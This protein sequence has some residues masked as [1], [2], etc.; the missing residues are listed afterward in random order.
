[1][2]TRR[3][4]FERKIILV[5]GGASRA[6]IGR[7]SF[8]PD[9]PS[10]KYSTCATDGHNW[11]PSCHLH[12]T[13]DGVEARGDVGV[14]GCHGNSGLGF[15]QRDRSG[16]PGQPNKKL[17]GPQEDGSPAE[18]PA[19]RT[20]HKHGGS[21]ILEFA[22]LSRKE[23]ETKLRETAA[24]NSRCS[25]I[26]GDNCG[27]GYLPGA[28]DDN[29]WLTGGGTPG[30]RCSNIG[31]DNCGTGYLPGAGDDND[32]LTGGGGT[33]GKRCSN[34]GGDNCGTGYLPGAGDDN[35][36]LTGGGTPG[37]RCSNIGGDNCGTGYLPGAAA[38]NS[39]LSGGGGP[40]KKRSLSYAKLRAWIRC[41]NIG[42]DNC[43]NG[44]LPGAG[45]DHDWMN[46]GGGPGKRSLTVQQFCQQNPMSIL[47]RNV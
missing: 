25:N 34:I 37:K 40:G 41:V 45:D 20:G 1:M 19:E 15:D 36:W 13:E 17:A 9:V 21:S 29:D 43:G 46:G 44:Y 31:G 27:T 32:W 30:K 12:E 8:A 42:G 38:D 2:A 10:Y 35:D 47:C 6:V 39:W 24:I 16:A 28:G 26:G 33:P 3:R 14:A 4:L 11:V 5:G 22:G 18:K 23:A 7:A